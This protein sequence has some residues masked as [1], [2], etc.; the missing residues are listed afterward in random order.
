MVTKNE[1]ARKDVMETNSAFIQNGGD[2]GD[3]E[4]KKP[5]PTFQQKR[6]L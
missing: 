2:Q 6:L 4:K 1:S 3:L 5:D